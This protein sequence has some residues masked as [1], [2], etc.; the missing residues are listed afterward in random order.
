MKYDLKKVR[1]AYGFSMRE[2][3]NFLGFMPIYY[4]KYEEEGE[5][6]SKYIYKLW[7][8]IDDFPIPDD[9]FCYTS[10]TLIVNMKYHKLTQKEVAAM[11]NISSQS[12][13]S[14][15]L[16]ENIPMYELKEYFNKFDPLIIPVMADKTNKDGNITDNCQ[17]IHRLSVK[18]NFVRA[19]RTKQAKA[20]RK[21]QL[22]SQYQRK[23]LAD[24]LN[25]SED[26]QPLP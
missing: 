6:P 9:F 26:K 5:I 15:L 23:S 3:G 1:Q 20:R 19:K 22:I 17:L 24:S 14:T 13:I 2:M 8:K 18:G 11:F 4:S 16:T 7:L 25:P 12:T 10:F 21:E